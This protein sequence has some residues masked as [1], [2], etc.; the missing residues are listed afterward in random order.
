MGRSERVIFSPPGLSR[1]FSSLLKNVART[2]RPSES[3]L[4]NTDEASMLWFFQQTVS[5]FCATQ[6]SREMK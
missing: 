6:N 5:G 2:P 3:Q 1:G 4:E